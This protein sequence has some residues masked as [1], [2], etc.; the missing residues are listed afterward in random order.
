MS[1][2]VVY[3]VCAMCGARCPIQVQVEGGECKFIQGNLHASGIKGALCARG[4]SGLSLVEDRDRPQFPMLRQGGRGEGKWKRISWDEALDL[5]ASKLEAARIQHGGKSILWS[6][7]GGPHADLRHALCRA[8]G[9]PNYTAAES[10]CAANVHHAALSLF[11]FDRDR[12]VYDYRRAKAVVLQT[13]NPFEAI[14]VKEV[15][16]LLD[17]IQSG[18]RLT[19]IDVRASVTAGKA[20]RF[21]MIRPG[22]DYALNLAV[23]NLLLTRELYDAKFAAAWIKPEDLEAL[24]AFAAPYTPEYAQAE[25]GIKAEEIIALAEEL[26]KAA[27]AVIWHPGGNASRYNDSFHLARSAYIINALLGSIGSKGGLPLLVRPRHLGRQGLKRFLDLFP[28]PEE[29]RA[30]GVGSTLP[31]F[32]GGP[33]LLHLAFKAMASGNP[34]PLKAYVVYNH[35]PLKSY[36]E[37]DK[38]KKAL[39]KMDFLLCVT[40]TWT[41]I[42]W[43]ADLV[44]PLSPHLERESALAQRNGLK[45]TFQMRARCVDP[46]FDTKPDWE[47]FTGLASRL[48][49]SELTFD[50]IKDIWAWQLQGTGYSLADFEEK[51][52]VELVDKPVFRSMEVYKFPTAS[53]KIELVNPKWEAQ[54]LVS[55]A[56]Y[57]QKAPVP[58]GSFR[59][60]L[61]RCPVHTVSYTQNNRLLN[62]MMPDNELWMNYDIGRRMGIH[63]GA[64]VEVKSNGHGG[65][66]KA[67]LS[68]FIHPE[69][70]FMVRGFGHDLDVETRARG[71]GLAETQLMPGGLDKFDKAG[72]G[73]A[74]Q[75]YV[76][77][78]MRL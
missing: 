19:V 25:T 76:V 56:P 1:G 40:P 29:K 3:S 67:R 70:V 26:A 22:T 61:G 34:Y 77:R 47:I 75:E 14:D 62:E 23:I 12:L 9:S 57:V 30:D 68:E 66:V 13:F 16:E 48:G 33:G 74:L 7:C 46:R 5:A 21:L 10:A 45:P 36:P 44:L 38:L 65:R 8:L 69:A 18:A 37:P 63:D 27:P 6:D 50:S 59:L 71:R 72:G 31:Q 51:G 15:N 73:L 49:V 55:L 11:G 32:A 42:A 17:G 43:Q 4:V 58:K 54:G 53:E 20:D 28:Q 41:E 78:V 2:K 24:K 39:E 64:E 35:D 60:T 52:F